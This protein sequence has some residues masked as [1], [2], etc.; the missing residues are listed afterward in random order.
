MEDVMDAFLLPLGWQRQL[1][2]HRGQNSCDKEGSVA[3]WCQFGCW[4]SQFKVRSFQPDL[5]TLCERAELGVFIALLG[6]KVL[7]MC[8]GVLCV[9][10]QLRDGL[11]S[12]L[13]RR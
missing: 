3:S 4:M 11:Y 1:I 12:G 2:D 10:S 6:Y 7:G 8:D 13:Y 5:L 9:G